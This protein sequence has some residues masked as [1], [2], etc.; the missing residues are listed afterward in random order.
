MRRRQRPITF[1]S[2]DR[3]SPT[4]APVATLAEE[5]GIG[6][7]TTKVRLPSLDVDLFESLKNNNA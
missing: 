1:L 6:M 2:P 4:P 3:A 7:V 5:H